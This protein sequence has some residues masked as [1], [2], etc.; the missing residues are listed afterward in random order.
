MGVSHRGYK[1]KFEKIPTIVSTGEK[2]LYNAEEM[3]DEAYLLATALPR[4]PVVVGKQRQEAIK[5]LYQHYPDLQVIILD[6]SFQHLQ[7]HHDL[8]ILSFC[9][10]TGLGNGFV[11]PAGYLRESIAAISREDWVVIYSRNGKASIQAWE[12]VIAARGARMFHSY[13]TVTQYQNARGEL[14]PIQKLQGRSISLVSGIANPSSFEAT[15]IGLGLQ[16]RSHY[17]FPDHYS[18]RDAGCRAKLKSDTSQVLLCTQK[19]LMK[20]AQYPE[21]VSRLAAVVQDYHLEGEEEFTEGII[22]ILK[23]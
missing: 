6:D 4:I 21:L 16:F 2:L 15:V 14:F 17:I 9:S 7:V 18:F 19:D 8:N 1:G 11:I 3:G 13:I 5:L 10:E 23:R 22:Q 20:L 12:R